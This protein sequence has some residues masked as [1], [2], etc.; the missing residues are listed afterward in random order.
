MSRVDGRSG[1]EMN[2]RLS[3]T[4]SVIYDSD[5]SVSEINESF[6]FRRPSSPTVGGDITSA[7]NDDTDIELDDEFN[8]ESLLTFERPAERRRKVT[9]TERPHHCSTLCATTYKA[10]RDRRRVTTTIAPT[11]SATSTSEDTESSDDVGKI[12]PLRRKSRF[13]IKKEETK[14]LV[15]GRWK[16]VGSRNYEEYLTELGA[17]ACTAH[18]MM[19]ADLVLVIQQEEDKQWRLAT[20]TLIKAKSVRGYR[21]NN[22]KWTENKFKPGE[23]KPELLE[24]WD[25]RLVVTT[26][27]LDEEGNW[28]SLEQVAERDQLFCKDSTVLLE[29]DPDEKDILIMTSMTEDTIAWKKFQRHVTGTPGH[30]P[31]R[32]ISAPF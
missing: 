32:K 3:Y 31:N 22:R 27:R 7:T 28:L 25:Q 13:Q 1:P 4:T 20:E 30:K 18:M 23:A 10:A 15:E 24:D 29:V 19:R 2:W 5:Y 9:V 16:Q 6:T 26:L 11:F 14:K 21:T 17:G 12:V 8:E